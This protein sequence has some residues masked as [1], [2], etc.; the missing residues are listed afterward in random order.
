M[1]MLRNALVFIPLALALTGCEFYF[2]G[3]GDDDACTD[4]LRDPIPTQ[5]LRNPETG[6]CDYSYG[7]GGGGGGGCVR[8]LNEGD[9]AGLQEAP[10][11]YPD[12][13]TCESFCTGLDEDSCRAS[14]GCRAIYVDVCSG[15]G[16]DCLIVEYAECWASAPSGPIRGGG[17]SGLDPFACSQHDDCTATHLSSDCRD[18]GLCEL[19][20]GSFQLCSDETAAPPP[21]CGTLDEAGCIGRADCAPLYEGSN[22]TCG[23]QGCVCQDQSFLSCSARDT[24]GGTA[25]GP[26]ACSSEQYCERFIPGP[27]GGMESFACRALPSAC[28]VDDAQATCECFTNEACSWSCQQDPATGAFTLTCAAP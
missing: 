26:Y 14:D 4:D 20:A 15:S 27:P 2:G 6:A 9:P 10:A 16:L 3:V 13:A 24:S 17:C 8:P 1:R 19:T 11:F 12:W 28:L 22:C 18:D 21:A 7:G 23:P 25:C 5:G